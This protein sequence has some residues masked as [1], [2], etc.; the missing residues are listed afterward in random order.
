[1]RV[2]IVSLALMLPVPA[3]AGQPI[4]ES[5]VQCAQLFDISNRLFPENRNSEKGQALAA[6]SDRFVAAAKDEAYREGRR[7]APRYVRVQSMAK[8]A[9]WDA[10]GPRFVM[11]DEFREW[12][13]YCRALGESR[14]ISFDRP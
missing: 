9:L 11:T 12:A 7:D 5:L 14:G 3:L 2:L 4:S 8:A 1:M 13:Q 10:K 6:L